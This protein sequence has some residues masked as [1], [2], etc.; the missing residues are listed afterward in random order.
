MAK[1]IPYKFYKVNINGQYQYIKNPG[2]NTPY[3]YTEVTPEE[4]NQATGKNEKAG[5]PSDY[6]NVDGQM[7]DK[8]A[9]DKTQASLSSGYTG[10]TAGKTQ[11]GVTLYK[12][13]DG[14]VTA[15]P[16]QGVSSG[17]QS[18]TQGAYMSNTGQSTEPK[19]QILNLASMAKYKPSEYTRQSDGSVILN[20]GVKPIDGTVK[21]ITPMPGSATPI[22][23]TE[24]TQFPKA[25]IDTGFEELPSNQPTDNQPSDN[26]TGGVADLS[27]YDTFINN[28]P[29]LKE[30]FQDQK[31]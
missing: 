21:N 24:F 4:Y 13:K 31:L 19:Y 8:S 16:P 20:P 1:S 12:L 5:Q 27:M 17:N 11:G 23:P 14:S 30:Q 7:W 2:F 25:N 29:F 15:T 22:N 28:D 3:G 9:Y 26:Q 18:Q 6:V 10:E